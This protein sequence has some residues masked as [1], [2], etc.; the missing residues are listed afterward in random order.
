MGSPASRNG[1]TY[2]SPPW[3]VKGVVEGARRRLAR[4]VQHK[5][6]LKHDAIAEITLSLNSASPSLTDIR[7]LFIL[8]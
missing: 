5:Q 4:P 7:F 6:P 8:L 2:H 1:L 3:L